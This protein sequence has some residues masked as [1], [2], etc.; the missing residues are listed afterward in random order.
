MY[1]NLARALGIFGWDSL[2]GFTKR[3]V[4]AKYRI[5]A[6]ER[7]PDRQGGTSK[8]FVLL[9]RAY[10]ILLDEA[11]ADVTAREIVS[12]SKD[13]LVEKVKNDNDR[14]QT[15]L[16]VYTG[17]INSQATAIERV[18]VEVQDMI[19]EFEAE[20]KR[21]K[22]ELDAA[23]EKLEKGFHRN[24]L[25]RLLFFWSPANEDEFWEQYNKQVEYYTKKYNELDSQFFRNML[26]I[27]GGGLNE[28]SQIIDEVEQEV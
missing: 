26:S 10:Q 8:E 18:K 20:K 22:K 15:K 27:Y 12:L 3:D 23:V 6:K 21:L 19:K 16:S 25:S 7:H 1:M 5:L 13:E 28:I 2:E 17:S 24:P 9:R 11:P 14:W 4:K